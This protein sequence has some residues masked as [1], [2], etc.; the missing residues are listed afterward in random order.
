VAIY[1]TF[2]VASDDELDAGFPGWKRPLESPIE[3]PARNPF[4][5]EVLVDPVSGK[6]R[7]ARTWDPD[8]GKGDG[9]HLAETQ[10]VPREAVGILARLK[11]LFRGDDRLPSRQV[12]RITGDYGDYLEG[13]AYPFAVSKPHWCGKG[14]TSVE[15]ESLH[16]A[17]THATVEAF[18]EK[19]ALIAPHSVPA[20]LDLLPDELVHALAK[21]ETSDYSELLPALAHDEA[22]AASE[23]DSRRVLRHLVGLSV[24]A[25]ATA[26]NVYLLTEW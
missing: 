22:W 23:E 1:T 13:R 20:S 18:M 5:G 24:D 2:F 17:L 25:T 12:V 7:L 26:R 14:V 9:R 15:L 3:R 8:D 19:P 10:N 6:P 11:R 21:L 4:T 16:L